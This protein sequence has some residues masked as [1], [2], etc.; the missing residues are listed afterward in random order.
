MFCSRCGNKNQDDAKYCNNCGE[1]LVN[2]QNKRDE[3]I[4]HHTTKSGNDVKVGFGKKFGETIGEKTAGFLWGIVVFIIITI[5]ILSILNVGKNSISKS[6][7]NP[8]TQISSTSNQVNSKPSQNESIMDQT[9]NWTGITSY[10]SKAVFVDGVEYFPSS[11]I[12]GS[13]FIKFVNHNN[14]DVELRLTRVEGNQRFI[15]A[16]YNNRLIA[17]G[18]EYIIYS[19][20][21]ELNRWKIEVI[22]I[23]N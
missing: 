11:G 21:Q 2:N 20:L 14:Y 7:I 17:D 6:I 8:A 13:E 16:L 10:R 23:S 5:I 15:K 3:I 12:T 19:N 9:D 18:G 22:K 1:S 4:I